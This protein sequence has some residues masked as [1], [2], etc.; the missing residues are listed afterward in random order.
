MNNNPEYKGIYYKKAKEQKF[1]EG[2]AHFKYIDLYSLLDKLKTK[3][4]T[5][6]NKK[7]LSL[8]KYLPKL[9][10]YKLE[11][12]RNMFNSIEKTSRK[13]MNSLSTKANH[14]FINNNFSLKNNTILLVLNKKKKSGN[15]LND[16]KERLINLKIQPLP[17]NRANSLKEQARK[18][19]GNGNGNNNNIINKKC[20]YIKVNEK[21]SI[22]TIKPINLTNKNYLIKTQLKKELN[23]HIDKSL[24][25]KSI[26][27]TVTEPRKSI[28]SKRDKKE[29]LHDSQDYVSTNTKSNYSARRKQNENKSRLSVDK[30]SYDCNNRK[31][32]NNMNR[33]V[34]TRL[35]MLNGAIVQNE[36]KS[37][38]LNS[39]YNQIMNKFNNMNT[40]KKKAKRLWSFDKGSVL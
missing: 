39:I 9:S 7:Q 1:Y 40:Q 28:E 38:K 33:I 12:T 19:N 8:P 31:N 37:K 2:R 17:S 14:F 34:Y 4:D 3:Q 10:I 35:N 32:I 18:S 20:L 11:K 27:N 25:N 26:L 5:N 15:Y 22:N 36:E 13:Q 6:N 30:T 21:R 24:F 29:E 23:I 16:N